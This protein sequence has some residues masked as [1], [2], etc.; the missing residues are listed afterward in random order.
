MH[1]RALALQLPILKFFLHISPAE[2]K[3]RLLDRLKD[4]TKQWKFN[5]GDLKERTLWKDYMQAYEDVLNKTSTEYAPWY[6]IP[7]DK[8][9]YRDLVIAS[10]LVDKLKQL[11]IDYPR[12]EFD[13]AAML[14]ELEAS[15]DNA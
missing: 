4:D 3:Q 9:W 8:K 13:V 1:C 2:Q 10:I 7:A 5:P 12:P 14:K 15:P 6:L 11:K